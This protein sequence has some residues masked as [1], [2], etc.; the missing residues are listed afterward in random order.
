[1]NP[2]A[3]A[4][5]HDRRREIRSLIERSETGWMTTTDLADKVGIDRATVTHHARRMVAEGTAAL[6]FLHVI[7]ESG[8]P[9]RVVID[10]D[11]LSDIPARFE[12]TVVRHTGMTDTFD[13]RIEF[14]E[15]PDEYVRPRLGPIATALRD[16]AGADQLADAIARTTADAIIAELHKGTLRLVIEPTL[17]EDES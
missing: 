7:G 6:G 2:D 10:P 12:H 5:G 4:T 3:E 11:R 1:M 17:P 13:A 16:G 15:T 14:T 9:A 8:R